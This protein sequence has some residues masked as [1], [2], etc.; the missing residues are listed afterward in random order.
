MVCD[1]LFAEARRLYEQGIRD[2][3]AVQAIGYKELYQY[4]D[5]QLSREQAIDLLK[6]NSRRYAKRQLTWFKNKTEAQWY[7]L[8]AG[9]SDELF[10]RIC[11]FVEGKYQN[12]SK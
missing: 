4:F 5:G 1:G 10:M 8:T 3:Q 2:S 9:L 6:Q 11:H 12:V 7:D